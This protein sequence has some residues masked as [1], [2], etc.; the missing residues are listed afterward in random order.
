[1]FKLIAVANSG[2][3]IRFYRIFWTRVYFALHMILWTIW[4]CLLSSRQC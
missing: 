3:V 1:M 4:R 2:D